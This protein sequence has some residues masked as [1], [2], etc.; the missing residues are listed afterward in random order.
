MDLRHRTPPI[1]G[2][3]A[4]LAAALTACGAADAKLRVSG[5]DCPAPGQLAQGVK[6][7]CGERQ[8]EGTAPASTS[9]SVP[10][11]DHDGQ[12]DCIASA[13]FTAVASAALEAKNIRTGVVL[14]GI[15]GALGDSSVAC[16]SDGQADCVVR[17]NF[18]AVDTGGVA[19]KIVAGEVVAGVSGIGVLNPPLSCISNA[20]VGCLATAEY[21][22]IEA[23]KAAACLS[24]L[25]LAPAPERSGTVLPAAVW[26]VAARGCDDLGYRLPSKRELLLLAVGGRGADSATDLVWTAD[27]DAQSG[28]AWAG[29]P[30]TGEMRPAPMS[31]RLTTLCVA[32]PKNQNP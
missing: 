14:G 24:G 29:N 19:V 16:T 15:A 3:V 12:N 25:G 8:I 10:A 9:T 23:T 27:V 32:N 5:Y 26:G 7:Q 22:A 31:S 2:L 13:S 20:A 21:P 17:G 4:V 11:C 6:L 1:I 28:T 18:A 30:A